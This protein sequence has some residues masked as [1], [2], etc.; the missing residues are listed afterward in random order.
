M[1]VMKMTATPQATS[2]GA[3]SQP[4]AQQEMRRTRLEIVLLCIFFPTLRLRIV[5]EALKYYGSVFR[6]SLSYFCLYS[7]AC[8]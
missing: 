4:Y 5:D 1:L 3:Q 6:S 8:S 2:R 7:R